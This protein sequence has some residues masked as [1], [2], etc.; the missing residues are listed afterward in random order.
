MGDLKEQSP[1]LCLPREV[2][3]RIYACLFRS[4]H[5]GRLRIVHPIEQ[6]GPAAPSY[7][8]LRD[9]LALFQTCRLVRSEASASLYGTNIFVFAE[10]EVPESTFRPKYLA[11]LLRVCGVTHMFT[12]LR[13]IGAENRV[14]IRSLQLELKS[15]GF[16]YAKGERAGPTKIPFY[17]GKALA[18]AFDLLAQGH[19]LQALEIRLSEWYAGHPEALAPL[20]RPPEKSLLVRKLMQL[21]GAL[22]FSVR[23]GDG[24]A[25]PVAPKLLPAYNRLV[26][27]LGTPTT[28][29][30]GASSLLAPSSQSALGD[31]QTDSIV[32]Q[33]RTAA[34]RYAE[35]SP[36]VQ[37][38]ETAIA[39]WEAL[40]RRKKTCIVG[41]QMEMREIDQRFA[42][43]KGIVEH[44]PTRETPIPRKRKVEEA[45]F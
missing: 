21:G 25:V 18:D 16:L 43:L 27:H 42:D 33:V 36:Y 20:L 14:S 3:D 39:Q 22:D 24:G 38:A 35:L 23:D 44:F 37:D 28:T 15:S 10:N 4:P 1:F 32:A 2:Q 7:A 5:Q 17:G 6:L 12:F 8:F 45:D 26:T 30:L 9:G 41:L 11:Y 31:P 13:L 34:Q 29:T 40:I 19:S